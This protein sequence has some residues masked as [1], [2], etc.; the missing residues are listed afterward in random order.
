MKQ[1]SLILITGG[2]RSGK[3]RM[4]LERSR[5]F[6][7]KVF[8]ATAEALDEEM[9]V[10]IEK[11]RRERGPEFITVEEPLHLARAIRAN[12]AADVLVIDCL[13]FWLNNLFHHLR[14]GENEIRDF[15]KALDERPTTLILVTNEIGMGVVPADPPSRRFVDR[16]G[17]LNQE[18]AHR[19]DEVIL[20]VSGIPQIV[21]SETGILD[22]N[23]APTN[24]IDPGR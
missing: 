21:K 19:A 22:G 4:A 8:V 13:T 14:D 23:L 15:L 9:R 18:V 20:M 12:R 17:W 16:Q 1:P 3:S 6:A 7:K 24:S 10:R 5:G 2:S 11:H